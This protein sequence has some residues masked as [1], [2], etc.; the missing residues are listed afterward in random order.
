MAAILERLGSLRDNDSTDLAAGLAAVAGGDLTRAVAP[1]T[2]AIENPGTDEIGRV[3]DAVNEIVANTSASIDAYNQ[4]REQLADLVGELSQSA[5]TVSS[6][7]Q[8]MAATSEEAGRAVGEIASA[9][10]DVAQGAERQVRMVESTRAAVNE[11]SRMATESA[12]ERGEHRRGGP[13]GA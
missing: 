5:G 9:V 8:Q 10:S 2:A 7:S 3:A 12:A 1:T 11:A 4:M 6:A 13:E